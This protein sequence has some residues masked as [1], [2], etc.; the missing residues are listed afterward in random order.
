[1]EV[2]LEKVLEKVHLKIQVP[3]AH[4]DFIISVISEEFGVVVIILLLVIFLFFIYNVF[5]KFYLEKNEKIKL[6]FRLDQ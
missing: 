4:T 3:D 6:S 1:M 5:K 2:F